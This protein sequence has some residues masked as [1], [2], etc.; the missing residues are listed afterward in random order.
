MARPRREQLPHAQAADRLASVVPQLARWIERLLAT[1]EPPLT[2]AQLL[3]LEGAEEG[4]AG[5]ELAERAAVSPAAVSQLLAGLEH[6]G[7][8]ERLRV[9][10]DRRRQT[11][12]LT[13]AGRRTLRS[14]RATL[15]RG[16]LP[17]VNVLRGPEAE[18]LAAALSRL[19][20]AVGA[21]PPPRP[22]R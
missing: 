20:P 10:D 1:H 15:R 6:A 5:T 22:P 18:A 7:L 19:A 13:P 17:L 9:S 14:V 16:L 21:T 4:L 3:A 11:V 8:V 2:V 12:V